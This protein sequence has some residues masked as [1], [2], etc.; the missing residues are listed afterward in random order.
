MDFAGAAGFVV[1]NI[2][3]L[4]RMKQRA[5]FYRISRFYAESRI[6]PLFSCDRPGWWFFF[7]KSRETEREGGR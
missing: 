4:S 2:Y 3:I 6:A 1:L 5:V 7:Y